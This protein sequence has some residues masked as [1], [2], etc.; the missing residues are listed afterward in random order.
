VNGCAVGVFIIIDGT[1]LAQ[2]GSDVYAFG[3]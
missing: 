2:I 1:D 3:A